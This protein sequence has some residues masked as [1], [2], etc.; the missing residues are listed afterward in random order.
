M[1]I[2]KTVTIHVDWTRK[3]ARQLYLIAFKSFTMQPFNHHTSLHSGFIIEKNVFH[4]I[5][6]YIVHYQRDDL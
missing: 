4:C 6:V 3:R 1:T 5:D 2:L